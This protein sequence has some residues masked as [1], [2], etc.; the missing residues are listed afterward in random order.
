MPDNVRRPRSRVYGGPGGTPECV[1][2]AGGFEPRYGELEMRRSRLSE[3]KRQNI[4]PMKFLSRSRCS[5]FGDR[6]EWME[7]RASERNGPFGEQKASSADR[8]S[9]AKMR[10]RCYYWAYLPRS[11]PGEYAALSRLAEGEELGSNLLRVTLSSLADPGD[12]GGFSKR[13]PPEVACSSQ[14]EATDNS[15]SVSGGGCDGPKASR[16]QPTGYPN[17]RAGIN[18]RPCQARTEPPD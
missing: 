7:S 3:R 15:R 11:S 17:E 12:L 2:E 4:V 18:R 16:G 10:N 9:G 1:A 14:K 5:N 6:A 8:E 13:P